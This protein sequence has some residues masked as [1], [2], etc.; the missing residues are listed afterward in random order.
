M[1]RTIR[2]TLLWLTGGIAALWIFGERGR[3]LRP[4]TRAFVEGMGGWRKV[5][6]AKFWDGYAYMRWSNQYITYGR[7]ALFPLV[8]YFEPT[9]PLWASVYHGKVVPTE[10]A[11]RLITVNQ[12]IP[13]QTVSEQIVPHDIARDIVLQ[14]PPDV[15]VYECPCRAGVENPCTPTQVCM[16][17]GQ[18]FVDFI[19][20]HNPDTSRRLTTQE[21]VDLLQAEHD[22]GHIHAMYFKDVMLERFYAICNCCACCCGGIQAMKEYGVPMVIPS[23]YVAVVD[24][25]ECIACGDCADICPFDAITVT[26][27]AAIDWQS[28]MGCGVC[29]DQCAVGALSLELD[30]RKGDPLTVEALLPETVAH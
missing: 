25:D 15:A 3:L 18:P 1:I 23:G 13:F 26:D 14:G 9:D 22:R 2:T 30:A 20:E 28:C 4:S 11:Q 19:L 12:P 10:A 24:E 16:I 6:T 29:E 17:V 27:V 8:R 7:R 5:F 21:A